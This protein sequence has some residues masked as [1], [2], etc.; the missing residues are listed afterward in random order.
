M[1]DLSVDSVYSLLPQPEDL[2][3][4][5]L[6]I[7]EFLEYLDDPISRQ[8]AELRVESYTNDQIAKLLDLNER[9]IGAGSPKSV[10]ATLSI[11]ANFLNRR[12]GLR[13]LRVGRSTASPPVVETQSR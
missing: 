4:I 10:S 13:L 9:T 11:L 3:L 12:R 5:K 7:E 6:E 8:I 1:S 2:A